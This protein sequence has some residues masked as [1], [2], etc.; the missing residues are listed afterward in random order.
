MKANPQPLDVRCDA[1]TT[2]TTTTR[3][4]KYASERSGTGQKCGLYFPWSQ[5]G[6]AQ[7]TRL[8]CTTADTRPHV[9]NC[10][11]SNVTWL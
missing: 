2:H 4:Y 3:L 11:G 1:H 9:G 10:E 8:S 7:R 5:L 6:A